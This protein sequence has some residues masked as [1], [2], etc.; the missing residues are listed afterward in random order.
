MFPM[1]L[2]YIEVYEKISVSSTRWRIFVSNK[3][4]QGAAFSMQFLRLSCLCRSGQQQM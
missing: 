3:A 4:I 2:E 1:T